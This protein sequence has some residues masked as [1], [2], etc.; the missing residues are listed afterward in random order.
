MEQDTTQHDQVWNI[1]QIQL[2]QQSTARKTWAQF[3]DALVQ[4]GLP[5]DV[6]ALK[7]ITSIEQDIKD[8]KDWFL[9]NTRGIKTFSRT[10]AIWIALAE[11]YNEQDQKNIYALTMR[12]CTTYDDEHN[13]WSKDI[14]W[15][16]QASVIA[17]DALIELLCLI[18]PI[19][20][21][22]EL[23]DWILP[24]ALSCFIFNEI[25]SDYIDPREVLQEQKIIEVGLGYNDGDYMG[26]Y[27]IAIR[28]EQMNEEESDTE[29]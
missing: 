17:P 15:Q 10:K 19:D 16:N 3:V 22:F 18:K 13:F 29:D 7:K 27:P 9:S 24:L 4:Y 14:L 12:G 21:N 23:L 28:K 20:E 6:V 11:Y 26:L 2:S 5:L 1:F 8:L 25:L